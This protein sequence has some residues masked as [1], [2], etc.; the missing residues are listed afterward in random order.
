M[1]TEHDR[2]DAEISETFNPKISK[3]I[4]ELRGVVS[5]LEDWER[6]QTS[7]TELQALL[8]DAS[9][10]AELRELAAED[11]SSVEKELEEL[12]KKLTLSLAPKDPFADLPCLLEIRP[13]AGGD[14]AAIFASELLRMYKA[15]CARRRFRM[16]MLKHETLSGESSGGDPPLAE[17]ILEIETP[18]TYG[19]LR[20]EAGVHRVQRVP[21]TESKGR[22]H[23]SAVSVVVLPSFPTSDS[24]GQDL[25]E[26]DFSDPIS[27]YYVNVSDVRVD[28]MKSS[29]AGGQHVNTTDSAVRLTHIPSGMVVNMQDSRSQHQNRKKAWQ[30][31]RSKLAQAKRE[32]REEERMKLRRTAGAQNMGRE[33]KVRTYNWGQQRVT[34]HRSGLSVHNLDDVMEAGDGLDRIIESVKTWLGEQEIQALIAEDEIAR[35][36]K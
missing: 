2:L 33:N 16:S 25:M 3:R 4:G 23:T 36:K 12:L 6:A 10:D 9:T 32:A 1:K 20:T 35:S 14:E 29:G 24:E 30:V 15:Y 31:L 5:A 19:E 17:A 27:D 13:G 21:A 7:I 8:K 18:G 22:T 34:D 28:T 11:L 26:A